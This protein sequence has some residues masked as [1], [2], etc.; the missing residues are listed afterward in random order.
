MPLNINVP[1]PRLQESS[2][3]KLTLSMF[4]PKNGGGERGEK[5]RRRR[6]EEDGL[7][8]GIFLSA[9]TGGNRC[10]HKQKGRR[11]YISQLQNKVLSAK[12]LDY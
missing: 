6:K 10:W 7:F 2:V 8:C 9:K 4:W 1:K 11:I 12:I 5:K 3:F